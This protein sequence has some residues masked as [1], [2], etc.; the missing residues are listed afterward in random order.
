MNV[1]T[2][3]LKLNKEYFRAV[4]D[5]TKTFECRW[6]DRGFQTGDRLLLKEFDTYGYTFKNQDIT[7]EVTYILHGQ[8]FGIMDGWCVMGIRRVDDSKTEGSE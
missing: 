7:V 1:K 8:R 6:N 3:E 4:A 2:H 5:G